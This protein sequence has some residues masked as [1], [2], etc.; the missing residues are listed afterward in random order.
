[1][2]KKYNLK[3]NSVNSIIPGIQI[4]TATPKNKKPR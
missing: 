3:I 4:L 2:S 1:M